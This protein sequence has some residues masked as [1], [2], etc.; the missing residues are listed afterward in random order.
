M[1]MLFTLSALMHCTAV[2]KELS[3]RVCNHTH[4]RLLKWKLNLK[5][6]GFPKPSQF[7]VKNL[8]GLEP[9]PGKP[10]EHSS[11]FLLETLSSLLMSMSKLLTLW[12]DIVT[13]FILESGTTVIYIKPQKI[14]PHNSVVPNPIAV[15]ELEAARELST[16]RALHNAA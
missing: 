12:Y 5:S 10:W 6:D 2:W 7:I 1:L 9:R 16:R 8:M 14:S 4:W 3:L 11:F 15:L 13:N